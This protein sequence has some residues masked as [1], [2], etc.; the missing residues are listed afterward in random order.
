MVFTDKFLLRTQW[1]LHTI[2]ISCNATIEALG[3]TLAL[4]A[5]KQ[6][7]FVAGIAYKGNFRQ[8]CG[9]LAPIK[10]DKG[11]LLHF[12]VRFLTTRKLEALRECALEIHGKLF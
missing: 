5:F 4:T 12:A 10:S 2:E 3:D 1:A 9:M 8:Y 6:H 7:A 11:R